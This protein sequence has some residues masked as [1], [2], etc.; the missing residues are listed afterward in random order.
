[1]PVVSGPPGVT[2]VRD[3]CLVRDGCIA[4]DADVVLVAHH[5]VERLLTTWGQCYDYKKN[6]RRK[7]WKNG[8]FAQTTDSFTK[9]RS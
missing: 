7:Y 3:L 6:L 1:L 8:V 5:Q 4:G 9:N 2:T